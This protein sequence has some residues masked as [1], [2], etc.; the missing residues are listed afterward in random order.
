MSDMCPTWH[1]RANWQAADS[2]VTALSTI[3]RCLAVF[4]ELQ[5][6]LKFIFAPRWKAACYDRYRGGVARSLA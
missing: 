4:N 3:N 1:H 6:T 2:Y 5:R